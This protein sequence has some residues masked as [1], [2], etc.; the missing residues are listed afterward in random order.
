[1]NADIHPTLAELVS[2]LRLDKRLLVRETLR[3]RAKSLT[4]S[5]SAGQGHLWAAI[6][7]DYVPCEMDCKFC[8]FG[9][10]WTAVTEERR[11]NMDEVEEQ[12]RQFLAAGADYLVLRTSECYSIQ[13]LQ[14]LAG[15]LKPMMGSHAKLVANTGCQTEAHWR[16]LRAAGFDGIY[17]TMRLREGVDTPFAPAERM[18][19][20]LAAKRA[21]LEIFALLEPVG[22][23]HT[24]Q[25]L[26][27]VIDMLR[28]VIRPT[29][30]GAMARVP[31]T[32][33]PMEH[34]GRISDDYLADLTA[35]IVLAVL[36]ALDEC[37]IVCSHPASPLL[38]EAG[39][40]A[41]VVE[42]GA[43][44]RDTHFASHLWTGFTPADVWQL[45]EKAGYEKPKA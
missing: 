10:S 35:I 11:L 42:C 45:L 15:R 38:V 30:V 33:S 39:V 26:Y 34:L 1:M 17:K 40:N 4:F 25:E 20:I 18:D 27:E 8:S 21:G 19:S 23:E 9:K 28:N 13:W 32:G 3:N 16:E 31:V 22:P 5:L 6:G 44:P 41:M 7:L 14:D 37:R 36:P 43:I 29:L 2:L 24:A 12:A